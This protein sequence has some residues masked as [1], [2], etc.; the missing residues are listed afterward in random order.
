MISS[1]IQF[2]LTTQKTFG[3]LITI[4]MPQRTSKILLARLTTNKNELPGII[5]NT[6]Y[7]F[8][9][10]HYVICRYAWPGMAVNHGV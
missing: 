8:C 7:A 3:K 10:L 4:H 5:S 1:S 6:R 9:S 2:F